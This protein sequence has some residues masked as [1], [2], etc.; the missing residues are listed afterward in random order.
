MGEHLT[1]DRHR[2]SLELGEI[3]E[4]DLARLIAERKDHLRIRAV[5]RL[6]L[7]HPPLQ[8]PL[9]RKPVH[10]RLL[11]LQVFQQRDWRQRRRSLQQWRQHLLPHPRQ[12]IGPGATTGL[13]RPWLELVP[14]NPAG[15]AHRDARRCRRSL[16][17]AAASSFGHVK[18]ALVAGQWCRHPLGPAHRRQGVQHSPNRPTSLSADTLSLFRSLRS[19]SGRQDSNLRPSAPKAE[20]GTHWTQI[21][22][23]KVLAAPAFWGG[24]L[25]S[26]WR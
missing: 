22:M 16:L 11:A 9:Q 17:A 26:D 24:V 14:L 10:I 25:V 21:G 20:N 13:V 18:P 15:T 4:G 3:T 2:H 23:G 12:R 7:P 6:P 1:R 5:Q 8:G 19:Q